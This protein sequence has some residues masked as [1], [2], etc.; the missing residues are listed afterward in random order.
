MATPGPGPPRTPPPPVQEDGFWGAPTSRSV[1]SGQL[2]MSDLFRA[3][4]CPRV[5]QLAHRIGATITYHIPAPRTAANSA[6]RN[7]SAREYHQDEVLL[8]T[9]YALGT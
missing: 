3:L 2:P 9:F 4:G 6:Q 5:C 1:L 7:A 8:R